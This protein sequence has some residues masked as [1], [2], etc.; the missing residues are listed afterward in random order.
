MSDRDPIELAQERLEALERLFAHWRTT[1]DPADAHREAWDH[2]NEEIAQ[3]RAAIAELGAQHQK[4]IEALQ[5]QLDLATHSSKAQRDIAAARAAVSLEAERAKADE[6]LR[7][8][9]AERE[10][11]LAE[12]A[13]LREEVTTLSSFS[14]ERALALYTNR[15]TS[16][17]ARVDAAQRE[18][19]ATQVRLAKAEAEARRS[20][21]RT[22][23]EMAQMDLAIEAARAECDRAEGAFRAAQARLASTL[24]KL[25]AWRTRG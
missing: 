16:D 11:L 14:G 15:T 12:V 6:A 7:Q 24:E 19:E 22:A 4:E 21:A 3:A 18:Y 5:A 1:T 10:R 2:I 9:E 13:E 25:A 8:R 20:G 23:L 17:R